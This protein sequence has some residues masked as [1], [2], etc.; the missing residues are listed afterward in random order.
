[1]PAQA[2]VRATWSRDRI[3]RVATLLLVGLAIHL[4]AP[5]IAELP[6]CDIRLGQPVLCRRSCAHPGLLRVW[7]D[8]CAV[9]CRSGRS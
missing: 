5:Q 2:P 1:M 3:W 9:T 8:P 6:P 7:K 4:L